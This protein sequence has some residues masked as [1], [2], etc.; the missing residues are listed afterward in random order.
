METSVPNQS[1]LMHDQWELCWIV[2][3]HFNKATEED[4]Q[5]HLDRNQVFLMVE[6]Q[7]PL[8]F[9]VGMNSPTPDY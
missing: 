9:G 4:Q 6:I 8:P 7:F 3:V 1:I 5:Q 2:H